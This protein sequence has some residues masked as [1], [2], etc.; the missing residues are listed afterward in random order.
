MAN[1]SNVKV[2]MPELPADERIKNFDEVELGYTVEMAME[3]AERCL[4]CK[5]RPC[6]TKG[7]PIG[8]K[9]P[10]FIAQIVKGEFLE[11]YKIIKEVGPLPMV[12]SRVCAQEKQCQGSCVRGIKGEPVAIGRLERFACDYAAKENY[13]VDITPAPNTAKKVAI[14]GAGPAGIACAVELTKKG[15]KAEIFEALTVGGGVMAYGIPEFRLPNKILEREFKKLEK[16][17]IAVKTGYTIGKDNTI[18]GLLSGGYEAV[19]VG[20]GAGVSNFMGIAGEDLEG[21]YSA[22]DYLTRIN[23]FKAYEEGDVSELKSYKNVAVIG[24]GNV[25]MDASRCAMRMNTD[26]VY[27]VYRRSEEELPARDDEVHHTKAEGVQFKTLVNPIEIIGENGKV[28]GLKCVKMELGE[29][30]DSGRR[31]PVAI[32]G[33]EFVLEADAVVMAIG[34]VTDPLIT[35]SSK[36]IETDRWGC[37]VVDDNMATTM[38][39][40]YAGGD[41]VTGPATVVHAI[42]W[43]KIAANSIDEYINNK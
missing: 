21:V 17:G 3:E 4:N 37:M 9:I 19:F 35:D 38:P 11:A 5:H 10:E 6:A 39:G 20:S 8:I 14:V 42:K 24:G 1:M 7:C 30:D 23:L 15:Y 25:A 41:N 18:E 12:C 28:T 34:S 2:P 27:V 32:E 40:V 29:P 31:K 22:N 33:S 36:S 16:W 13:E 26:N 43:G